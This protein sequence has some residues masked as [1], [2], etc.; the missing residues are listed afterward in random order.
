MPQRA[1]G[2]HVDGM[3]IAALITPLLASLLAVLLFALP[4]MVVGALL[5]TLWWGASG[6]VHAV[7]QHG[8]NMR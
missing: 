2:A 4:L 8:H 5:F 7:A 6:L 3:S 1:P